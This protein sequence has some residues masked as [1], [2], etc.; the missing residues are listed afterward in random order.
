VLRF[1]IYSIKQINNFL[2]DKIHSR[3]LSLTR[4]ISKN[5]KSFLIKRYAA[6]FL[7]LHEVSI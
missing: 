7:P 5:D 2:R 4:T 3:I 1:F 6:T